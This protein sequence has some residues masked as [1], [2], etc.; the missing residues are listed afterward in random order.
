[1]KAA[2]PRDRFTVSVACTALA[3]AA[4][5]W[6]VSE[7]EIAAERRAKVAEVMRENANLARTF[8]EHT[9]RTLGYVDGIVLSVKQRF[10][11]EGTR[12]DLPQLYGQL[13]P[14]PALIRNLV[15]TDAAGRV[16]LTSDGPSSASLADREHIRVHLGAKTD[17]LFIGKPVRGRVNGL[18]SLVATRRADRP[19]GSPAGVVAIAI[20][21]AY[22]SG[23]YRE[24]DLGTDGIVTLVGLDGVVRARL[25]RDTTEISQD[26]SGS[27]LMRQLGDRDSVAAVSISKVDGVERIYAARRV[28]GYP[29]VV[30][31]GTGTARSLADLAAS[32]RR[33]RIAAGIETAL[34][35]ALALLLVLFHRRREEAH[36]FNAAVLDSMPQQVA[37][38]DRKG[39]IVAVNEVWRR[40]AR[41]NGA[42][43]LLVDPVGVNYLQSC[44]PVLTGPEAADAQAVA[45]G[46]RA[47]L[48]GRQDEFNM[49]YPCHSPHEERWFAMSVSH[50]HH[51]WGGVVVSHQDI[52]EQI[53]AGFALRESEKRLRAL[54]DWSP[55]PVGIH[56]G[57]IIIFAN[58][59]AV[60]MFG[61]S[62]AEDL[63]GHSIY[64]RL[65]PDSLPAARARI[66]S[67][68]ED[69]FQAP[70]I[71][72]QLLRM[73][74]TPID[75]EVEGR[76]ILFDG[77]PA[78][79]S[80]LHDVTGRRRSEAA[81]AL[82][83]EQLRQAQKMAAVGTLAGG[84][85][86]DFNNILAAILGNAELAREDTLGNPRAIESLEEIRRAGIRGRDLVHQ[87][88]AFSRRQPTAMNL[89]ALGEVVEE[90][91]R[92]LR[93]TLPSSVTLR[94]Q[95]APGL[96]ALL[97]DST[98][99]QQVVLNLV[100]N[101]VQAMQGAPGSVT[102][103]LD[104][105]TLDTAFADRHPA[106]RPLVDTHPGTALRLAVS[107]DGPGMEP[108][109]LERIF[110]PFFTTKPVGQGTGLGLSVVH[111]IVQT[112]EG[113]IDASSTPGQGATF[114]LYLPAAADPVEAAPTLPAAQAAPR[115]RGKRMLYVDDDESL[116]FLVERLMQRQ[117]YEVA[118]FTRPQAA[119]DALRA[120]PLAFDLLVTDYN[121]PGM[122][123]L[124]VA[125]KAL[126]IRADLPVAVASGF[127]DET[128]SA[129]AEAAG[130]LEVIF[131]AISVEEY[132]VAL[133]RLARG[134]A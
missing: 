93:A 56:R 90:S 49:E 94:M 18:W 80:S 62:C 69:D 11:A 101:A 9:I 129:Q 112:H 32:Q 123:G 8:A 40:F 58:P 97:G 59:A 133:E 71:E 110:E 65:H 53:H 91:A 121:M 23:F 109:V 25:A 114:T 76:T 29:L 17:Y 24:I 131:K 37:V 73:D 124:E 31:V 34:I 60:A 88:L 12:L 78:V 89:I 113:V 52:S 106:V 61:A 86:H 82:L 67:T 127:I 57:G 85:A 63:V 117:G 39:A 70:G 2:F 15:V 104:A 120:A 51:G 30:V 115:A 22:F 46:I 103:T 105:V 4:A 44:E 21:P 13:Q 79:L 7:T 128:L 43:A 1:M 95:C 111:G 3:L 28:P 100:A 35:V 6:A 92:L 10:E 5:L 16:V 118:G 14:P 96:P 74:G 68:R 47:V 116:V 27:E 42:P 84:I 81:R 45:A 20:D 50:M 107:D 87:I 75:V 99:L 125:R 98:Q 102:L 108:A 48:E 122:S 126:A 41:A 72:L 83:E 54:V 132:G 130:V 38:L 33:A 26:V 119:L 19:D 36:R 55:A 64:E 66:E 77:A 134:P